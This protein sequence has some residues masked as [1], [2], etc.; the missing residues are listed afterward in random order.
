MLNFERIFGSNIG[1]SVNY[2]ALVM[3]IMIRSILTDKIS[4][5]T[6]GY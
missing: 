2:R 6:G 4:I 5:N 3:P 1:A